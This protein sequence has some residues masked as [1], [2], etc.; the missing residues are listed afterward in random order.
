M[1]SI[2]RSCLLGRRDF[3]PRQTQQTISA[4]LTD[5][6]TNGEGTNERTRRRK[7]HEIKYADAQIHTTAS[8]RTPGKQPD[9]EGSIAR[10][11]ANSQR[12]GRQGGGSPKGAGKQPEVSRQAASERRQAA[13]NKN[14]ASSG[15]YRRQ[16]R[17]TIG[18]VGG[19]PSAQCEKQYASEHSPW[20]QQMANSRPLTTDCFWLV[21]E[22]A[23]CII[24]LF[25]RPTSQLVLDVNY[26][27]CIN[28]FN[29]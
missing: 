21:N 4:S 13:W 5:I 19:K 18:W 11:R 24:Y 22:I 25:K 15:R 14:P 28:T 10:D 17:I 16:G 3:Q 29:I 12:E 1:N 7:N 26:F 27:Y 9:G 8:S 20:A 6:R 2:L 23:Q